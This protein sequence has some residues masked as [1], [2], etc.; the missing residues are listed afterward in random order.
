M[1]GKAHSDPRCDCYYRQPEWDADQH[2]HYDECP[3]LQPAAPAPPPAPPPAQT[4]APVAPSAPTN[5]TAPAGKPLQAPPPPDGD[6]APNLVFVRNI[7]HGIFAAN[8]YSEDGSEIVR[9]QAASFDAVVDKWRPV[10]T[11]YGD[12]TVIEFSEIEGF[13]TEERKADHWCNTAMAH[14]VDSGQLTA[15]ARYRFSL[16]SGGGQYHNIEVIPWT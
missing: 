5:G 3:T 6:F 4:P 8:Q 1:P 10:T 9:Y 12:R 11:K 16:P 15:G 14:Y 7:P 2:A 13:P